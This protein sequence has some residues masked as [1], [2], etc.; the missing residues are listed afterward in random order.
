[1]PSGAYEVDGT[2]KFVT[3]GIIDVHGHLG[4][5]PSPGTQS[6]S[7]GNEA[8]RPR[9]RKSGP[10]SVWPQDPGFSRALDERRRRRFQVLPDR[11]TCSAAES[12]TLKNVP[13][14]GSRE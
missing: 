14:H 12:V 8:T 3:P 1:M 6:H 2:G 11:R 13:A 10:S 4:D 7:D 5:Y 9:A